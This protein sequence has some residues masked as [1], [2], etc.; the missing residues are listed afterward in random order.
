MSRRVLPR[1]ATVITVAMALAAATVIAQQP[2]DLRRALLLNPSALTE[3]APPIF[4]T[5]FDTSA[6]MFVIRV[7][8]AWAP[9]GADRFYNLVKAGFYENCRFFRVVPEF[10]AQFGIH[11][12]PAVSEA[13][14]RA[15]IPPDRARLSN[16]RGRVTF[17]MGKLADTRTTQVFIN[18][19]DNSDL[20]IEG[21]APFGEVM[22]SMV[23]VERIYSRYGEGPDQGR[24]MREGNAFL[25]KNL[26]RMDYIRKVTIEP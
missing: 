24:I 2:P 23:L 13:W 11:G 19:G 14:S 15:T 9:N 25:I 10:V 5:L 17:A 26:P 8:R 12:D 16:T 6:G 4:T 22:S 21:F 3:Q 7:H 1:T 20:D 18:I